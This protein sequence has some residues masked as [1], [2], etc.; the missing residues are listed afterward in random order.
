M[1]LTK[2]SG[3]VSD[4]QAVSKVI[5]AKCV[6]NA[7]TPNT[8]FDMSATSVVL[9]KADSSTHTVYSTGTLTNNIS[10][11]GPAA[12]GRDQAGV[13]SASSFIHMFF[14]WNGTTLATLSSASLTPTLPT[15]YTHYAY[16][17]TVRLDGSVHIVSTLVRGNTVFDRTLPTVLSGGTQTSETAVDIS[18]YVPSVALES[19]IE[20]LPQVI[21]NAGAASVVAFI[22]V[23]SGETIA[24]ARA[25][26]EVA[27]SNLT[28]SQIHKIP[29]VGTNIY[30]YL[31]VIGAP[32]GANTDIQIIGYTVPNGG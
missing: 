12:N 8:Q 3:A 16:V 19:I 7:G 27:A 28:E 14:I 5:G 18:A 21:A 31:V 10:T 24:V 29:Y 25:N 11:A 4:S 32:T 17:A 22:G 1:G 20:N 2:V 6:N 26:A 30:Y 9:R 13:F 15:G 23:I